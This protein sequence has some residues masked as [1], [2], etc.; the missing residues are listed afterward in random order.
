MAPPLIHRI[1]RAVLAPGRT[2]TILLL[3]LLLLATL[4]LLAFTGR[5]AENPSSGE[6]REQPLSGTID[7]PSAV[8]VDRSSASRDNNVTSIIEGTASPEH[9]DP[10]SIPYPAAP[11]SDAILVLIL[12]DL[13][14]NLEAGQRALALPG[15][16]TFAVLPYTP[17][18]RTLAEQAHAAGSELMLHAPM[19]NLSDMPLGM[20][21]LTPD[22]TEQDFRRTLEESIRQVPHIKGVNNHTG[23]DLTARRQPMQWV[24]DVLKGEDLYFVDSV[25]TGDTVAAET[26]EAVGIPTLR[27]Q[28]FLDHSRDPVAIDREFRRLLDIARQEGRAVGIGHPYP[29]T[30]DYLEQALP[31]LN[32]LGYRLQSVSGALE[33]AARTRPTDGA[34]SVP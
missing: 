27:R 33:K 11:E 28:V 34:A 21:G 8:T 29:E 6:P 30:L 9:A 1:I 7:R 25:T 17:H 20:G 10:P 31:Q 13:G 5:P 16:I 15:P 32:A 12:D 14:N 19:S 2:Q 23:S 26:A 3:A 24:M 22:L 4:V 18:A